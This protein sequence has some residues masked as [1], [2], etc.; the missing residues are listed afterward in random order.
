MQQP[1]WQY[2]GLSYD[3]GFYRGSKHQD[4]AVI[5]LPGA[6]INATIDELVYIVLHDNLEELTV[7]FAPW[8]Y[9]KYVTFGSKGEM[10][11]YVVLQ[12]ALYI[13]VFDLPFCFTSN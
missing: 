3:N 9:C 13:D 2:Y 11:L 12:K 8:I 10:D 4:V 7:E 1:H 6:F 5:Y